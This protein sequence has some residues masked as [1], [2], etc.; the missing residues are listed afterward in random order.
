MSDLSTTVAES[1][2]ADFLEHHRAC[3]KPRP[4]AEQCDTL[5]E[6]WKTC[7][8]PEPLIWALRKAGFQELR[9]LMVWACWCVRQVAHF[10]T[11]QQSMQALEV[12]DRFAEGNATIEE[13]TAMTGAAQQAERPNLPLQAAWSARAVAELTVPRPVPAARAALEAQICTSKDAGVR[14]EVLMAQANKLRETIAPDVI[15]SLIATLRRIGAEGGALPANSSAEPTDE[16][17]EKPG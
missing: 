15:A 12:A 13:L 2:F 8:S 9:P 7:P 6:A 10:L 1:E 11:E 16:A 4:W 5:E 17:E 3:A 14:R